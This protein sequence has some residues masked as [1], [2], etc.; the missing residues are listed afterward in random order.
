MKYW[1]INRSLDNKVDGIK[2]YYE[3]EKNCMRYKIIF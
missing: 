2:K 1:E 3:F